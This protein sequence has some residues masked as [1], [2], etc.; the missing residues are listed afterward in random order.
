MSIK[1]RK[2]GSGKWTFV[3][4]LG[5][6][7]PAGSGGGS[8]AAYEAGEGIIITA[9]ESG[10]EIRVAVPVIPLTKAEYE[11]LSG[12][13]RQK[14]ALYVITD[15]E[16]SG[17][18]S[19]GTAGVASFKGRSGAVMPLEGDYTAEMVGARPDTWTP[20]AADVGARPDTWTPT[21]ADV[22]ARPDTWMPTAEDIG[23]ATPA[24]VA[25]AIQA[26]VLDS[27]EASY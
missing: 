18:P 19:G 3:S 8:G 4:G 6:P 9:T 21:A 26:A 12:E 11:A 2:K 20:T 1:V 7:G 27:W 25:A 23:A 17:E 14:Q 15:G 10:S 13:E 22:G 5:R 24:G 16:V